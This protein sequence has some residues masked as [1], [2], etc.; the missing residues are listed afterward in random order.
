LP[1]GISYTLQIDT[2]GDAFAN[3]SHTGTLTFTLPEGASI[4]STGGYTPSAIPAPGAGLL[5]ATALAGALVRPLWRRRH[6]A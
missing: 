4:T 6:P 5:L 3:F 1:F 2:H